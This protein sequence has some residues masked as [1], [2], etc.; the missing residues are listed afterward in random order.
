[1]K[2]K[3]KEIVNTNSKKN[4]L[5]EERLVVLKYADNNCYVQVVS[6]EEAIKK[7][8]KRYFGIDL[9]KLTWKYGR[10]EHKIGSSRWRERG[11]REGVIGV[12]DRCDIDH[13]DSMAYAAVEAV[14]ADRIWSCD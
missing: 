2:N 1:M 12:Y 14:S 3:N 4:A 5:A 6:V 10:S 11:L 9:E 7:Y 8:N 13:L